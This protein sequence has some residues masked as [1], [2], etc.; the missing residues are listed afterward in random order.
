MSFETNPRQQLARLLNWSDAHVSF[1]EAVAAYRES[2]DLLLELGRH[3]QAIATWREAQT[4][5]PR[6]SSPGERIRR[7]EEALAE[8]D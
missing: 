1:D 2:R 4:R 5:A 3:D 7:A 8:Q 6:D